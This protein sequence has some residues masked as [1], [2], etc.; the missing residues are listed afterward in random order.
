V[1][2][3]DRRAGIAGGIAEGRPLRGGE[4]VRLIAQG[5]RR[6]LQPVVADLARELELPLDR[7]LA[8]HFVAKRN[9]HWRVGPVWPASGRTRSAPLG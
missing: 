5:E 1:Q 9:A 2:A 7:Q 6:D 8:D 4:P 3:G